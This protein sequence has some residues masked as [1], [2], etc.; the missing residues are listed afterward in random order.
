MRRLAALALIVALGSGC[1]GGADPVTTN[2]SDLAAIGAGAAGPTEAVLIALRSAASGDYEAAAV[3]TVLDQMPIVAAL[4]GVPVREA[5]ELDAPGRVAVATRFWEGFG[6]GIDWP[7]DPGRITTGAVR[8]LPVRDTFTQVTVGVPGIEA[9]PM[10]VSGGDGWW[11]DVFASFGPALIGEVVQ[12]TESLASDPSDEASRFLEL[13]RAER[14]SLLALRSRDDLTPA[15]VAAVDEL[16][17]L[18]G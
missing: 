6:S 1:S 18:L 11:V 7:D 12:I 13:L 16:L 9:S 15:V 10:V 5:L 3:V 17:A 8:E 14:P 2:S 4:E